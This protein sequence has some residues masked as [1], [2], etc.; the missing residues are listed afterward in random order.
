MRGDSEAWSKQL[1]SL[2]IFA[3]LLELIAPAA[4]AL[5]ER[6]ERQQT[7]P[8]RRQRLAAPADP[9]LAKILNTL[10]NPGPDLPGADSQALQDYFP[11]PDLVAKTDPEPTAEVGA[12]PQP[13]SEETAVPAEEESKP[14][15]RRYPVPNYKAPEPVWGFEEPAPAVVPA[16]HSSSS[17]HSDAASTEQPSDAQEE[18]ETPTPQPEPQHLAVADPP[19]VRLPVL[20][21]ILPGQLAPRWPS[22]YRSHPGGP[23]LQ[24]GMD[25]TSHTE[26]FN[27]DAMIYLGKSFAIENS[28]K[29]VVYDFR[30]PDASLNS[31]GTDRGT[32]ASVMWE[33]SSTGASA[34]KFDASN[35]IKITIWDQKSPHGRVVTKTDEA[36][37]EQLECTTGISARDLGD[38]TWSVTEDGTP[39]ADQVFAVTPPTPAVYEGFSRITATGTVNEPARKNFLAFTQDR[40]I[41][42]RQSYELPTPQTAQETVSKKIIWRWLAPEGARLL[43]NI[44]KSYLQAETSYTYNAASGY[45][46][47][48]KIFDPAYPNGYTLSVTSGSQPLTQVNLSYGEGLPAGRVRFQ[49]LVDGHLKQTRQITVQD[50]KTQVSTLTG[51]I[52]PGSG[53]T[54][55]LLG[56]KSDRKLPSFHW[57]LE[58][59]NGDTGESIKGFHGDVKTLGDSQMTL[60]VD[61]D[62]LG[63]NNVT[64]P[65][66]TSI[67]THVDLDFDMVDPAANSAALYR[68]PGTHGFRATV[69]VDPEPGEVTYTISGV[70]HQPVSGN[71]S[72]NEE[73][74]FY[75][76]DQS[77]LY[78]NGSSTP[79]YESPPATGW[80]K[81]SFTAKPGDT[82]TI[83]CFDTYGYAHD[84]TP[85]AIYAGNETQ[86]VTQGT[87]GYIVDNAPGS[88]NVFLT[89]TIT[90]A[91]GQVQ[92]K[93]KTKKPKSD[94]T[95]KTQT[96]CACDGCDP[97]EISATESTFA[98]P[99]EVQVQAGSGR[100]RRSEVDLAVRTRGIPLAIQRSYVSEK[101]SEAPQFGWFWN[102]QEKLFVDVTSHRV[103]HMSAAGFVD[104]FK[105]QGSSY[106]AEESEVTDKLR[107]IDDRHYELVMKN[108][109]RKIFEVPQGVYLP[110]PTAFAVLKQEI[111]ANGN[112]NK[113]TWDRAGRKMT[114]MQGPDSRQFICVDWTDCG[115]ALP[116]SATDHTG[117][118]VVYRYGKLGSHRLLS[119]VVQPGGRTFD[120][121]YQT[122]ESDQ[123]HLLKTSLNGVLQEK[124]VSWDAGMLTEVTH[125]P[126]KTESLTT[127]VD[128]QG[129][130]TKSM[131]LSAAGLMDRKTNRKVDDEGKIVSAVDAVGDSNQHSL[132]RIF[133]AANNILESTDSMGHKTTMT[134]DAHRNPLSVTDNLGHTT[135]M[136]W[137]TRDN[138]LTVRT[139]DGGLTVMT[140]DQNSNLTSVTDPSGHRST[141]TWT[142]FGKVQSATDNL[143]HTWD[144]AYD[145]L[146]FLKT[147]TAPPNASG[148]RAHWNYQV[149][150]L[151]RTLAATNP[152]GHRVQRRYDQRD[153]VVETTLPA[154]SARYRQQSLPEGHT[155]ARY[156]SNDLLLASTSLDGLVTS[157]EYDPAQRLTAV[158]QPGM[159]QPTRLVYDNLDHLIQMINPNGQATAYQFD[160]RNRLIRM[161]YP[162]GQAETFTHDDNNHLVHWNRGDYAVDYSFDLG[163]RLSHI[164]S[165]STHDDITLNYDVLDRVSAMT[166]NS[167][168]TQYGYTDNYLLRSIARPGNKNLQF[169]F[170]AGDRL[171]QI[172]D[173]EG[174][175]TDYTY[176]DRDELNSVRHDGQSI[177]Y[178]RD[179]LGRMVQTSYPNGVVER[180]TFDERNQLLLKQYDRGCNP[181]LTLKYAFNQLGQRLT[182]EQIAPDGTVLKHFLYNDRRELVSSSRKKGATTTHND[183]QTDQNYNRTKRNNDDF[184]SNAADQLLQAG[185][186]ALGYNGAGQTTSLGDK[187]QTFAYNDQLRTVQGAGVDAAYLYDGNGQRVQKTVNGVISKFLWCGSQICKEYAGDGT[188]KNDY[189]LGAGREGIK[190]SGAWKFYLTDI[191][192]STL[193]LTDAQGQIS[194]RYEYT[195]FGETT[196]LSGNS[197][198]PFLYTGQEFDSETGFYHLRARHYAPNLGKF[199]SR[200]PIGYAAGSNVY[201]Y[202]GGDP[203]NAVDPTGLDAWI[204]YSTGLVQT[205]AGSDTDQWVQNIQNSGYGD[206]DSLGWVSHGGRT[207]LVSADPSNW[208]SFNVKEGVAKVGYGDNKEILVS[209]LLKGKGIEH[210][211]VKGC[212]SAG[213]IDSHDPGYM[214]S[215][216]NDK[217]ITDNNIANAIAKAVPGLRVHGSRGI[218]T[219]RL[220]SDDSKNQ[221]SNPDIQNETIY[222]QTYDG[223]LLRSERYNPNP[224][225]Y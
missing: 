203:I 221:R 48:T 47:T 10:A 29:K 31:N 62:N 36:Q 11:H 153:R 184:V 198:N 172:L 90:I 120:Y 79:F 202:C 199:L 55:F 98:S 157:Y 146:G 201:S 5:P 165:P 125:R 24:L 83:K 82:L 214:Q 143:S 35:T 105:L 65:L 137:D 171:S 131:T 217:K 135:S 193:A 139:A 32:A 52:T 92:D 196:H 145:H 183:Y 9:Q 113:F 175:T 6:T 97:E 107:K 91:I 144:F 215:E 7:T 72:G 163:D 129:Q 106:Q 151:G 40:R 13:E 8:V 56:V 128:A 61:W 170:D 15:P 207:G 167:G 138:L 206:I 118:K 169:T 160:A 44:R 4:W 3:I 178:Q 23:F 205:Y 119:R 154:V 54:R 168:T 22:A 149:D 111:D 50:V 19:E 59:L 2:L 220:G 88:G 28:T 209:E 134:W 182:D 173:P 141:A 95:K 58:I 195:D 49:E 204:R 130:V 101:E 99:V 71:G 78:L 142:S 186:T 136:T 152:L 150:S 200:D 224:V 84:L 64:L 121:Q 211:Y 155:H 140:Y 103:L 133:D 210:F 66:G 14:A 63:A 116:V 108:H 96:N 60:P 94:K 187:T 179:L 148:Q 21:P 166:D 27:T 104:A 18:M 93:K 20:D 219:D 17:H 80:G 53:D 30:S 34:S 194:D 16:P 127:S 70:G 192:G 180:Q 189:I 77:K 69:P 132:S 51:S 33:Y 174:V 38:W 45:Q 1:S 164:S 162:G 73:V 197:S 87:G 109:S 158:H 126:D 114:R 191:Q 213:G 76:D 25:T 212:N 161:D 110:S 218:Y 112:T 74:G 42:Y 46:L 147:K 124:L 216:H 12:T 122:G 57:N 75:T 181:L 39:A 86:I 159:A 85:V 26:A 100:Y 185:P 156:D 37:L 123:A 117:R 68:E 190:N 222:R 81:T 188:V 43:K 67:D 223:R 41:N 102:W 176:S 89:A 177:H 208:L 115:D 225:G